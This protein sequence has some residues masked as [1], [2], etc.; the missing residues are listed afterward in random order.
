MNKGSSKATPQALKN[1]RRSSEAIQVS[2]SDAY[3]E[4][5]IFIL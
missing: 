1:S 3:S 5:R 2:S 4:A